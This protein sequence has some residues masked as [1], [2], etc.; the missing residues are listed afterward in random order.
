MGLGI[1]Q[2]DEISVRVS[3]EDKEAAA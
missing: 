2:G 3:G 1:R